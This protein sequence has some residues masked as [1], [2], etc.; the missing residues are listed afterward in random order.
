M[1][2]FAKRRLFAVA[3]VGKQAGACFFCRAAG[4]CGCMC[5]LVAKLCVFCGGVL[6]GG[7]GF[8]QVSGGMLLF[9]K[10]RLFAVAGVGK[11]EESRTVCKSSPVSRKKMHLAQSSAC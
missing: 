2:L 3:A 10:Q 4:A 6:V 7:G 1:L 11:Q 9:A 8:G 5:G